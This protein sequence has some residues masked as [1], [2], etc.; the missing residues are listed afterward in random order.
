MLVDWDR[1]FRREWAGRSA[2]HRGRSFAMEECVSP[3]SPDSTLLG[4]DEGTSGGAD[5]LRLRLRQEAVDLFHRPGF[6]ASLPA[7]PGALQAL[8]E[9]TTAD[10]LPSASDSH[11]NPTVVPISHFPGLEV[12]LC[13]SPVESSVYCLQEKA[14]WVRRHLGQDWLPRV[15]YTSQKV[16]NAHVPVYE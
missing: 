7:M 16:P 8:H 15:I 5:T 3:H 6:F 11:P 4:E 1:G 12:Y 14:D 13:T 2:I 10:P 9:M